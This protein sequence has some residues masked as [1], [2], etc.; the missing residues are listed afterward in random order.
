MKKILILVFILSSLVSSANDTTDVRIGITFDYYWKVRSP[1]AEPLNYTKISARYNWLAGYFRALH[2]PTGNTATLQTGQHTAAGA[3]WYDSTGADSGLYVMGQNQTFQRLARAGE[4]GGPVND[5]I[6]RGFRLADESISGS[7]LK[8]SDINWTKVSSQRYFKLIGDIT[9]FQSTFGDN[10]SSAYTV[11]G[12]I[13]TWSNGQAVIVG[14]TT[15]A[16]KISPKAAWWSTELIMSSYTMPTAGTFS[17]VG[18]SLYRNS[19]NFIA[20]VF[21]VQLD[22]F[23]IIQNGAISMRL[24]NPG[25]SK[26]NMTLYLSG[27]GNDISFWV[28]SNGQTR[29]IGTVASTIDLMANGL[30][31]LYKYSIYSDADAATNHYV[32]SFR[33]G[34]VGGM[35]TFNLRLVTNEDG[36]PYQYGNKVL[37]TADVGN[38]GTIGSLNYARANS[39]LFSMD[40]DNYQLQ[41]LGRFYFRRSDPSLVTTRIYGGT[42]ISI[43]WWPSIKKFVMDYVWSDG[44]SAAIE[45]SDSY[46]YLDYEA[47]FGE[48]I[49]D[50]S[51][52]NDFGYNTIAF[53]NLLY[54]CRIYKEGDSVFVVGGYS[55]AAGAVSP[56]INPI[57][58]S[59]LSLS[60]LTVVKQFTSTLFYE[61]ASIAR[62]RGATFVNYYTFGDPKG[63][64]LRLNQFDSTGTLT[65]SE[66]S[67]KIASCFWLVYQKNDSTKYRQ[68]C[69]NNEPVPVTGLD[70][71]EG[72]LEV[73]EGNVVSAGYE[74][75]IRIAN[76]VQFPSVISRQNP[77][78]L[79]RGLTDGSLLFVNKGGLAQNALGIGYENAGAT[80]YF[81]LRNDNTGLVVSG[82][83][84]AVMRQTNASA[85]GNV[86]NYYEVNGKWGGFRVDQS[87]N[88]VWVT[89][90]GGGFFWFV[91]G[92]FGTGTSRMVLS[93][94]GIV[95]MSAYGAGTAT[96]DASGVI[97]SV[98]DERAKK[99]IRRYRA[100]LAEIMKIKPITFRYNGRSGNETEHFYNGFSAQNIEYALGPTAVGMNDN[101]LKSVQERNIIAALVNAV[102]EQQKQIDELKRRLR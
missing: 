87:G 65:F 25:F 72:D 24:K 77:P 33:A 19:T 78:P 40:L 101:G 98:S 96:F 34:T 26:E 6:A 27:A 30:M 37:F 91:G 100:G 97:S 42:D 94:A 21:D 49:I 1:F 9:H 102:Q 35:G 2:I 36:S 99:D 52:F 81:R 20:G 85:V 69:F 68:V 64:C 51:Q 10:D 80:P 75:P 84:G 62:L 48:T 79:T 28:V 41:E 57:K 58:L 15:W 22:T 18:P 39:T 29:W 50:E 74:F 55:Q 73:Y 7:A 53:P 3:I 31:N 61:G 11:T 88:V 92:D 23:Y 95:T 17:R 8:P 90:T 16:T 76:Q 43:S 13:P 70:W 38:N 45:H 54:D 5:T 12:T 60:S 82:G 93:T 63:I 71:T 47:L 66:T 59:G 67:A 83:T 4:A 89:N 14:V 44:D 46:I 56:P 32:S 86:F